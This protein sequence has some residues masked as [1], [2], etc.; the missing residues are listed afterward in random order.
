LAILPRSKR[1]WASRLLRA[2][3][4]LLSGWERFAVGIV[5]D[6]DF[7][8]A[9]LLLQDQQRLIAAGKVQRWDVVKW[10]VTVNLGLAVASVG[11]AKGA[12]GLFFL[13]A[14]LVAAGAGLV[15]HYNKGM[16]GARRDADRVTAYLKDS[17]S[18]LSKILPVE[19][20]E[21]VRARTPAMYDAEELYIFCCI[22]SGSILPALF[23]WLFKA[24]Q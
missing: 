15:Y 17:G 6:K 2:P 18:D 14:I 22:I 10:S 3:L 21:Q 20:P 5:A 9:C 13:F 24:A 23:A 16:T 12:G 11:I 1:R 4:S 8:I 7:A 19:L